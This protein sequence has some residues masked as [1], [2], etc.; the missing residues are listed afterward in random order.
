MSQTPSSN[1]AVTRKGRQL[2]ELFD[3]SK[4]I[5]LYSKS[6]TSL[7]LRFEFQPE[8]I[9]VGQKVIINDELVQAVG[10]IKEIF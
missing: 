7:R 10:L 5:K 3:N 1:I 6:K 9:T 2:I 4:L 8:F